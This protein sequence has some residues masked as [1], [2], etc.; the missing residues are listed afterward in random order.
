M[1]HFL[2]PLVFLI[3]SPQWGAEVSFQSAQLVWLEGRELHPSLSLRW[4][5]NS[6]GNV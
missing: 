6:L 4:E 2:Y 1:P 3:A 5:T